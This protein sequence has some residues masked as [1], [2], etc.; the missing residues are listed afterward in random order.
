MSH[1]TSTEDSFGDIVPA[2]A[3]ILPSAVNHDY[4]TE[5]LKPTGIETRAVESGGN[6]DR[7]GS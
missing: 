2:A 6:A 1:P 7:S 4:V 5:G 3:I